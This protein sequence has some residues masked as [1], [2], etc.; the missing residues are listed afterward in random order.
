LLGRDVIPTEH[1]ATLGTVNDIVLADLSQYIMI[2]KGAPKQDSS[3]HVRFIN[4]EMTF[5]TT[6]RVDGQP[7]WNKALTPFA[8]SNTQ[9]PFI[10]LAVRS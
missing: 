1:N 5:R 2:D 8:G 3:M 7:W 4:D 10:T 6:Y 9:S